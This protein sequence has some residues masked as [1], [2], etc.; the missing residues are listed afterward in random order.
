M[1]EYEDCLG[2]KPTTEPFESNAL[3][4]SFSLMEAFKCLHE[5][6]VLNYIAYRK[7]IT[8]LLND[9]RSTNL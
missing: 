1:H 2:G 9:M 3:F 6:L 8:T 5:E 4:D 7:K